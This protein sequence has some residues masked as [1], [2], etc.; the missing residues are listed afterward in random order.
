MHT[1]INMHIY[2][3]RCAYTHIHWNEYP[4]LIISPTPLKAIELEKETP[5]V[6]DER[7]LLELSAHKPAWSVNSM[8][9]S[10]LVASRGH[11]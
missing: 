9:I 6:D 5:L 7:T 8:G 3:Y 10:R 2:I 1:H 4:G 11:M